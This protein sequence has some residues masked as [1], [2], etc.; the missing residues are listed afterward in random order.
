MK[1]VLHSY[2]GLD[3]LNTTIK[4]ELLAGFTTF[5]SMAYIL[6]SIQRSLVLLVWMR[7]GL[8]SH[9]I[10]KCPRMYFDGSLGKIPDCDSSCVRNQRVLFLF[11]LY[12]DGCALANGTSRC[13]VASL[14]FIA[15]TIFKL[16][17]MIIDAIPSDLKY[18]I[19]GGI[20]LFIAFLGLSE[21]GIIVSDDSTLVALG[22]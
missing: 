10:S 3:E 1:N 5:I 6:L 4:R 9:S 2:F 13:F 17:E 12:R 18:A 20:G 15:I 19:S 16:R 7:S 21:G 11:S 22:S 14:I 8:Y